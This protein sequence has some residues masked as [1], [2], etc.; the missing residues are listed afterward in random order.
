MCGPEIATSSLALELTALAPFTNVPSPRRPSAR[1]RC[2]AV[3][4][5]MESGPQPPKLKAA[6][7]NECGFRHHRAQHSGVMAIS[8][9]GS[10]RSA[11]RLDRDQMRSVLVV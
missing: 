3:V 11:F 10:S 2:E 5:G 8:V 4:M 7:M 6:A 1:S 9:P